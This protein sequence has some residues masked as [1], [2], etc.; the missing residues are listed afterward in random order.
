MLNAAM[1]NAVRIVGRGRLVLALLIAIPLGAIVA[2][3]SGGTPPTPSQAQWTVA[4]SDAGGT[5][6][7]VGVA[8]APQY[9]VVPHAEIEGEVTAELPVSYVPGA[10][11]S[12]DLV[13]ILRASEARN[14]GAL[15]QIARSTA[16]ALVANRNLQFTRQSQITDVVSGQVDPRVIDLLT[17]IASRRRITVTSMRT[18]HSTYVAGSSRV[19]AHHLG[20][21]VDI[22]A[23]NGQPCTG[24]PGAEC[25]RLFEEIVNSLR[26]TQYQPSQV[27]YGYDPWPSESWNFEMSNHHDHIHIGY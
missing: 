4:Y 24:G 22:A 21:A 8:P 10:P 13:A 5:G 3:P 18:D 23:V 14:A 12:T 27:I 20:R 6:Q 2:A 16:A 15:P 11:P 17:W 9:V 25:G 26:R 19:S 1:H 7:P